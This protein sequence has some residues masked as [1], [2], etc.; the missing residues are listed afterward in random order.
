MKAKL[1][2]KMHQQITLL[3]MSVFNQKLFR[4]IYGFCLKIQENCQKLCFFFYFY[5]SKKVKIIFK[6]FYKYRK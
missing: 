2:I 5:S 3:K 4:E 1:G 6:E